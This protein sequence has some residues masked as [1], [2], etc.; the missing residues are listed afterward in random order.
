MSP[1]LLFYI[2][3]EKRQLQ[4]PEKAHIIKMK[5]L[6]LLA[7]LFCMAMPSAM[8][9][10]NEMIV[11]RFYVGGAIGFTTNSYDGKRQSSTLKFSPEFGYN[12]NN[13]MS[14][15]LALGYNRITNKRNVSDGTIDLHTTTFSF[16]PYFRYAFYRD[17]KVNIFCDAGFTYSN[18]NEENYEASKKYDYKVNGF[19][20]GLY[21]GISYR[22]SSKFSLVAHLGS[23]AYRSSK[24]DTENGKSTSR[25]GLSLANGTSFGLFYNF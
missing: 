2:P 12:I 21:P 3:I 17:N 25:F 20:I 7:T 13:K 1:T 15:G 6:F 14:V 22:I 4:G 8:S 16:S 19:E 18:S 9:A 24:P 10:Q 11:T 23:L 5:K